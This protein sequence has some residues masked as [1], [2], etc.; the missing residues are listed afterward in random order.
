MVWKWSNEWICFSGEIQSREM[1]LHSL[2]QRNSVVWDVRNT[3]DSYNWQSLIEITVKFYS[4][5]NL[6]H[7]LSD[8]VFQGFC[9][10]FPDSVLLSQTVHL[11]DQDAVRNYW[12]TYGKGLFWSEPAKAAAAVSSALC[13]TGLSLEKRKCWSLS[14]VQLLA[15]LWTIAH[16]APLSKGF[17]RQE[18][19]SGLPFPSPGELLDPGIKSGSPELGT[20]SSPSGPPRKWLA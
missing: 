12:R 7:W 6:Y 14:R 13:P 10:V 8:T 18:Y 4:L 3:G 9:Y 5:I 19:W 20:D 1:F 16:Q 17:S 15:T 11:S 2:T